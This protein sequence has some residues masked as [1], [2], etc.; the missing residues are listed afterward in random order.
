M[1]VPSAGSSSD[2]A[3]VNTP[4]TSLASYLPH[5]S[6][7]FFAHRPS[8]CVTLTPPSPLLLVNL[9][10]LFLFGYLRAPPP[11]SSHSPRELRSEIR[12]NGR[13]R[14]GPVQHLA[15]CYPRACELVDYAPE[16]DSGCVPFPPS[17]SGLWCSNVCG[18]CAVQLPIVERFVSVPSRSRAEGMTTNLPV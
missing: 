9:L 15:P 7:T 14:G 1:L 13:T 5:A 17:N 3:R 12:N 2:P 8:V 4:P 6:P 10:L 16:Q 11:S 18:C